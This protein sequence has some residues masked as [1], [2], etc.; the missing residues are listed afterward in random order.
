MKMF[1]I[2]DGE[3]AGE[4]ISLDIIGAV[5]KNKSTIAIQDRFDKPLW[6]SGSMTDETAF[7]QA[8]SKVADEI[9]RGRAALMI[10]MAQLPTGDLIDP[11][12][13][14]QVALTGPDAQTQG[15]R[16]LSKNT[17]LLVFLPAP[18][19]AGAQAILKE[20]GPALGTA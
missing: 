15:V 16:V 7:N 6:I 9:S 4:L 8:Y 3:R 14:G 19:R 13:I 10:P 2:P 5:R 17:N 18:N 11:E 1:T 12:I 20:I